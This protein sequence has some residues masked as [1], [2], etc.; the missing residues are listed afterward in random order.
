MQ[1]VCVI[2]L[3]Y[4]GLPT[5]SFLATK[6]FD[7][8]GVDVQPKVV[9]KLNQGE[10][11]IIEPD[12]D[13]LVKSAVYSGKFKA[14]LKPAKADVFIIAVPTPFHQDKTPDITYV[15]AATRSIAPYLEE[16]NLVILESTSPVGTTERI[17]ELIREARPELKSIYYVHSPERV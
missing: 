9:E 16:G 1:T 10:I 8:H 6:G 5:A 13:I 7:V 12:L 15:E 14:H 3:G 11:H 4:I 17:R 2:G